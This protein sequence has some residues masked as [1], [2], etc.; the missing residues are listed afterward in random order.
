MQR[1]V[2]EGW[3]PFPLSS[4]KIQCDILENFFYV[5]AFQPQL[6][7]LC[8][9]WSLI[10]LSWYTHYLSLLKIT[11]SYSNEYSSLSHIHLMP[12][13]ESRR[14][15]KWPRVLSSVSLP[16]IWVAFSN[17]LSSNRHT[18]HTLYVKQFPCLISY[19]MF[20][21]VLWDWTFLTFQYFRKLR[22]MEVKNL[23]QG[24]RALS[25]R[26]WIRGSLTLNVC[27]IINQLPDVSPC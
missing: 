18:E 24:H 22:L 4:K 13:L 27:A 1:C 15:R 12:W 10:S 17:F 21:I 2:Q 26:A 5:L 14:V 19:L 23:S 8:L 11:R 7:N 16:S 6:C 3:T 25:G 9:P 20:I